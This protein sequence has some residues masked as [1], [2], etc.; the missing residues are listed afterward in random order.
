[1]PDERKRGRQIAS[2]AGERPGRWPGSPTHCARPAALC[3]NFLS[4][5]KHK[6][7]PSPSILVVSK[8]A[9]PACV[10]IS[11]AGRRPSR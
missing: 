10:F 7:Q 2:D 4:K 5:R 1:M 3:F 8:T 11:F 6:P 9:R